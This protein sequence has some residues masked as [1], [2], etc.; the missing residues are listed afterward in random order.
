MSTATTL[1]RNAAQNSRLAVVDCDIH[2]TMRAGELLKYL[3]P[4]WAEHF[5]VHGGFIRQGLS[6]ILAHP[7]MQPATSRVDSWPPEGG[8]PG[9]SLS[10]MQQQHLD[11]NGIEYGMLQPLGPSG[12]QRNLDFGAA[13]ATAFN[14]WQV[15]AWTSQEKR[16][17]AGIVIPYEWPEAAVAEI[18]RRAKDNSFAQIMMPPRTT[19]PAGHRHYWPIYQ[20]AVE[21][22]LPIGMHVGGNNGMPQTGGGWPSFYIED[23]H[24][25][26]QNMQALVGSYVLEGVF[27]RFPTLKV[28]LIEG[29]FGW[30]PSLA[31]RLDK[32]WERLRSEVPH[33]KRPPSEY[34]RTNLWYTSQPIEETERPEDFIHLLNWMGW[35][36]L[37]FSTDYPHW[38]FDDPHVVF[39]KF[40]MTQAQRAQLLRDNARAVYSR[41]D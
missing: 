2:P 29:G 3:E 25:N 20:A 26:V 40:H 7:R 34:M 4:R 13:L 18:H 22:D 28:V 31:W 41:L 5:K 16:L 36:R 9:S 33:V 15:D 1:E 32:V 12:T 39:Q 27:E 23:H 17:K 10:F 37:L 19:L 6:K 30:V 21:Y 38:D 24:T 14:D 35:D 8:P 11:G